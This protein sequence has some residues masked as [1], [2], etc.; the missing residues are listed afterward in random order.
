MQRRELWI[1]NM[2]TTGGREQFGF[3][4]AI[5]LQ[6]EKYARR[7]PLVIIAPLSSKLNL[8]NYAG[9]VR[10]EPT[11]DNGLTVPSIVM[12]F[13]IRGLDRSRFM[14]RLGLLNEADYSEVMAEL[15]R[16]TGRSTND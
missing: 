4:P 9:T 7:S 6:D 8:E 14:R 16:L 10:V 13:Q 5:V 2:P 15:D 1:V 12:V 11:T 3:R